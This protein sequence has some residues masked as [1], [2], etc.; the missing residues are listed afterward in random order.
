MDY[1]D[2][3]AR[4]ESQIISLHTLYGPVYGKLFLFGLFYDIDLQSH[5]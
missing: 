1:V 5:R 4:V 3:L 2:L